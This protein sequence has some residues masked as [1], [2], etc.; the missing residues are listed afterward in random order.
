MARGG[1]QIVSI[2]RR[3]TKELSSVLKRGDKNSRA[4]PE[5]KKKWINAVGGLIIGGTLLGLRGKLTVVIREA[6]W[7]HELLGT[8]SNVKRE[9]RRTG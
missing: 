6:A 3:K 9:R 2:F 1:S 5:K 4:K 8:Q 7:M